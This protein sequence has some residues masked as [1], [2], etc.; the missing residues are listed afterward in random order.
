MSALLPQGVTIDPNKYPAVNISRDGSTIVFAAANNRVSRLFTRKLGEFD[1][2][3]IPGTEG[4][5]Q[6]PVKI[7]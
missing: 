2:R 5:L 3:T 4:E 6:R 1:A 7:V